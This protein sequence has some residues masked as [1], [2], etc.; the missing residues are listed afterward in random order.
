MSKN[1]NEGNTSSPDNKDTYQQDNYVAPRPYE[2]Y[3]E[4][5]MTG[6]HTS[7]TPPV[8]GYYNEQLPYLAYAP[9]SRQA[10]KQSASSTIT[11]KLPIRP[12]LDEGFQAF[13][14]Y[15]CPDL[16]DFLNS[17]PERFQP[18]QRVV[19]FRI[20]SK[21]AI[22]CVDWNGTLCITGT[23]IVRIVAYRLHLF[24]RDVINRKKFEEGIF[25]DLRNLRTGSAASLE[26]PKSDLLSFLY[27]NHCVRTK[28]K[29][30][31]F[32]WHAVNHEKMFLETLEREIKRKNTY[33]MAMAVY[34][35]SI[36]SGSATSPPE[37]FT[38][39]QIVGEPAASFQ[40]DPNMTLEEQLLKLV[41]DESSHFYVS[42]V[43][44]SLQGNVGEGAAKD[45]EPLTNPT[46][47]NLIEAYD[48]TRLKSVKIES[49]S[50]TA[51]FG[52][53]P[54]RTK[55]PQDSR[56]VS[57]PRTQSF[58]A[59][60]SRNTAFQRLYMPVSPHGQS[61]SR[62]YHLPS[63]DI[64]QIK[65]T[66]FMN[67]TGTEA[68]ITEHLRPEITT[69][70]DSD[71][72][73]CIIP[74]SRTQLQIPVVS[75]PMKPLFHSERPTGHSVSS[76][77]MVGS[78]LLD[79]KK[80]SR[81]YMEKTGFELADSDNVNHNPNVYIESR[82]YGDNNLAPHPFPA[83][84]PPPSIPY[85]DLGL[86]Y[87]TY[88][89]PS[90]SV[91]LNGEYLPRSIDT[92]PHINN[93]VG[94]NSSVPTDPVVFSNSE[95]LPSDTYNHVDETDR[96]YSDTNY[97]HLHSPQLF[98]TSEYDP[99]SLQAGPYLAGTNRVH[100]THHEPSRHIPFLGQHPQN[101]SDDTG[102]IIKTC[103]HTAD[104]DPQKCVLCVQSHPSQLQ[105]IQCAQDPEHCPHHTSNRKSKQGNICSNDQHNKP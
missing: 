82:G 67:D 62:A 99:Q 9:T 56:R 78:D 60:Q 94:M 69:E 77:N 10:Y 79:S 22:S 42:G 27:A 102:L 35:N 61:Q 63:N 43:P 19:Q 31:V 101:I 65:H 18:G 14:N 28:K 51:H 44:H 41:H 53:S 105:C 15:L 90:T 81:S 85:T 29:Q 71:K 96:Y 23:D 64:T 46:G 89:P 103:T 86:Q 55:F 74:A 20:N 12:V 73:D 100:Y 4:N 91:S 36:E 40:F 68:Q 7:L 34:M 32:Y 97:R 52:R 37:C 70:S 83:N 66:P 95:F 72:S 59:N 48:N 17:A 2:L 33:D 30:K 38:V 58:S 45:M 3:N 5:C 54:P 88:E 8:T 57:K 11:S 49:K 84:V 6:N 39:T 13:F 47:S 98:P 24:G 25:S 93:S 75:Q 87:P 16:T 21:E 92:V 76:N 50:P 104:Q 26:Y 80:Y 1:N